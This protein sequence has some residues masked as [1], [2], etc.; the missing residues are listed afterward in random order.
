MNPVFTTGAIALL[1]ALL[2]MAYVAMRGRVEDGLVALQLAGALATIAVVCLGVGLGSTAFT[3]LA[4]ITAVM[5]W[6]GGL[7][8]ARFLDRRP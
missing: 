1:L 5:T 3:G 7:V 2:P 4:V 8:F 6:V